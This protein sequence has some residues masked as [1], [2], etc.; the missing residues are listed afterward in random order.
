MAT[1]VATAVC[2]PVVDP[3]REIFSVMCVGGEDIQLQLAGSFPRTHAGGLTGGPAV[4]KGREVVR[5]ARLQ[6]PLSV[7]IMM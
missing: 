4:N 5:S 3:D 1:M 7:M 6:P 2:E